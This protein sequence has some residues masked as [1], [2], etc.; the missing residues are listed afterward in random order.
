MD[1]ISDYFSKDERIAEL[2]KQ[3]S[4]I[5]KTH[6]KE[7]KALTRE[8]TKQSKVAVQLCK[9]KYKK[10]LCKSSSTANSLR[11]NVYSARMWKDHWKAKCLELQEFIDENISHKDGS[12]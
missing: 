10:M 12:E 4:D 1:N 7:V 2:E 6:K 11:A 5:K 3:I 9:N 8:S